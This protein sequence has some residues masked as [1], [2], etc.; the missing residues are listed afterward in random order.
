MIQSQKNRPQ[1]ALV[2]VHEIYGLNRF[3]DETA[4]Y[5]RE[6]GYDI[7]CPDLLKRACFEYEEEE[8]A[9]RHFRD[10]VGFV[11]DA[12]SEAIIW[13]LK[14]KYEYVFILGFSA[15]ATIAWKIAAQGVADGVVC[16]YGSRIRDEIALVPG[17]A[18]WLIFAQEAGF[19]VQHVAGL[20]KQKPKIRVSVVDAGHGFMDPYQR[21]YNGKTAAW[22]RREID[23]FFKNLRK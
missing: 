22:Y 8:K 5:Y 16:C 7:Y 17:C 6:Q 9:Y 23:S 14:R 1:A 11:V 13:N 20:L 10:E 21:N 15:G 18:T 2:L 3:I 19:D 12:E 4:A